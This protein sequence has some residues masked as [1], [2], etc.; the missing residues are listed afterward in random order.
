M[1]PRITLVLALAL[2]S[3]AAVARPGAAGVDVEAALAAHNAARARHCAPALVWS[4]KL[5]ASAQRWADTLK[6]RDCA[7][8]HTPNARYGENLA[9]GTSGM[10]DAERVV[11]MWYDEVS[12]FDF[13]K[14]GFSAKTGHFTQVVWK[15][16]REVGCGVSRC[17]G[18]DVWVCQYDPPGNVRGRYRENVLPRS[19]KR[20]R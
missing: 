6:R 17:N 3:P 1:P 15:A 8:E 12:S 14:G 7:F 18:M 2:A 4:K 13:E 19:C 5:A 10:M 16:T 20:G 11:G 9:A